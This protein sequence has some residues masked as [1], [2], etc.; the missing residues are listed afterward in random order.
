MAA[1]G[2]CALING[3]TDMPPEDGTAEMAADGNYALLADVTD[4][5]LVDGTAN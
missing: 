4:A 3:G 5:L 2:I 1:D